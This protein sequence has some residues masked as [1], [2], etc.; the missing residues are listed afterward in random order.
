[1]TNNALQQ[2]VITR[3]EAAHARHTRIVALRAELEANALNLGEALFWFEKEGQYRTLGHASFNAY[4]A[5][6]DVNI[7]RS[8]AYKFK[9]VYALFVRTLECPAA[10]LLDAGADKLEVIAPHVHSDNVDE[11]VAKAGTL[12]RSDL[13]KEIVREF[14]VDVDAPFNSN[15]WRWVWKRA[16]KLWRR[17]AL[18][19]RRER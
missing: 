3:T 5:D 9:R 14:G 6:P 8:T 11:W 10:G 1:M 16:A 15:E 13:R 18:E 19:L 17:R 4:L 7:A 12:S 2:Q